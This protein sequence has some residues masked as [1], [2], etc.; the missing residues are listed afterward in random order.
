MNSGR[1][2]GDDD[3]MTIMFR[4]DTVSGPPREVGLR[5]GEGLRSRGVRPQEPGSEFDGSGAAAPA[6]PRGT[7]GAEESADRDGSVWST[8]ETDEQ[9]KLLGRHA[10]WLL[11]EVSGLAQGLGVPPERILDT[12]VPRPILARCGHFALLPPGT[13]DG[14]PYHG[15]SYEF[16]LERSDLR[17][18]STLLTGCA[19]HIGFSELLFGRNDG[20]NEH[21]LCV[22]ISISGGVPGTHEGSGLHYA[23]VTRILLDACGSVDEALELLETLPIGSCVN[24]VLSDAGGAA[25]LFEAAGPMHA[26]K[27]AVP[28]SA[29][30]SFLL[31][32]NHYTLLRPSYAYTNSIVRYNKTKDWIVSSAG[33]LDA[34]TIQAFL[35][36]PYPEGLASWVRLRRRGTLWAM[37]FDPAG[38]RAEIRFGP[39]PH[40]PWRR[41]EPPRA[42]GAA[43]GNPA[44]SA[45]TGG[46]VYEAGFPADPPD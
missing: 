27:R 30:E 46:T 45:G 42:A 25:A 37:V 32:T 11:E 19:G 38:R 9:A 34:R 43:A 15:R 17:L 2:T 7:A 44:P 18:C 3:L 40:N 29:A 33:R 24:L 23:V 41:F 4:H 12:V 21:G 5:A 39:P 20:I 1:R 14:R 10:P 8:A 35:E 13:S 16:W 22:S 28:G 6:G 31:S 26:V 36:L